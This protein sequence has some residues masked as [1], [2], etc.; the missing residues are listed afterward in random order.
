MKLA[1]GVL[2]DDHHGVE[3]ESGVLVIVAT[4]STLQHDLE[5]HASKTC[6]THFADLKLLLMREIARPQKSVESPTLLQRL[7]PIVLISML[8]SPSTM[9]TMVNHHVFHTELS[10][11]SR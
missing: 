8:H 5:F 6:C 1:W 11:H 3:E 9:N 2:S 4:V 7:A 10:P